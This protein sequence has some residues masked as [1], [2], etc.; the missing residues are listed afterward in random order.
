MGGANEALRLAVIAEGGAQRLDPARQGRIGNNSSVPDL[1]D[2]LILRDEALGVLDKEAKERKNLRFEC[3]IRAVFPQFR[4]QR[5][6][7]EIL[8]SVNHRRRL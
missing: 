4:F 7:L 3:D 6:E 5:V 1:F 8:K 2:D